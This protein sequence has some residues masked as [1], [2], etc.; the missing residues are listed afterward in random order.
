[1]EG[2]DAHALLSEEPFIRYHRK[3]FSGQLVD[4]YLKDNSLFPKQRL[5]IDSLLT[6][7]AMVERGVGVSVV[8][9]SFSITYRE[10]QLIKVT[11]PQRTHIRRIGMIWNKKDQE[12]DIARTLLGEQK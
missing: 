5:E 6:I 12:L 1:M 2:R 3:A 10:H 11:L 8:P 7:V 4:R 9:D